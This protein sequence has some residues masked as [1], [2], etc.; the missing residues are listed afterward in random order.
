MLIPWNLIRFHFVISL[1]LRYLN[2]DSAGFQVGQGY[3]CRGPEIT[4]VHGDANPDGCYQLATLRFF[5][6]KYPHSS[7][8]ENRSICRLLRSGFKSLDSCW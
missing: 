5:F 6:C 7:N 8:G 2:V 4:V 1:F 3:A